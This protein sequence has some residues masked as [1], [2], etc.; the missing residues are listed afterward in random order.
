MN[1]TKL[2]LVDGHYPSFREIT[3][4]AF[5]ISIVMC[6]LDMP[7]EKS[8]LREVQAQQLVAAWNSHEQLVTLL[9]AADNKLQALRTYHSGPAADA[10]DGFRKQIADGLAAAAPNQ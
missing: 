4:L 3:G 9:Q 2:A 1:T 7:H 10:I 6:A 5:P 8:V